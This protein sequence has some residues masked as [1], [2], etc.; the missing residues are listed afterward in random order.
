MHVNADADKVQAT[1]DDPRKYPF[2]N[3]MRKANIDE[4]PQFINVLQGRMSIVGPRPH[5]LAH[6]EQYSG[7]IDKYMV[8]HFVKPGVTGWALVHRELEHLARHP[9]HLANLQEH[10]YPR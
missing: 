8:R 6:T 7:L 3:F 10:V 1:K 2:G 5:M 9:H 4:L